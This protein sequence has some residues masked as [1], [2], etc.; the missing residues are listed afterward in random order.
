MILNQRK[1]LSLNP[2]LIGIVILR[3]LILFTSWPR[4]LEGFVFEY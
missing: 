1:W 3:A 2:G 4:N